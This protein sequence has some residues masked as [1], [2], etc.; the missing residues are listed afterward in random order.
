MVRE[1]VHGG[2]M[3]A[4]IVSIAVAERRACPL[5]SI[6][7]S[8]TNCKGRKRCNFVNF[9]FHF[10]VCLCLEGLIAA[11]FGVGLEFS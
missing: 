7:G 6:G 8:Q 1:T 4:H 3:D 2:T 10:V 11:A 9:V 5:K